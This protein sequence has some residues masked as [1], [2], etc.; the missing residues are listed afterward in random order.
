MKRVK[1]IVLCIGFIILYI[2]L[3]ILSGGI[4]GFI[5]LWLGT[6]RAMIN[7]VLIKQA[8]IVQILAVAL[9]IIAVNGY[10]RNENNKLWDEKKRTS[11]PKLWIASIML[12]LSYSII[13]SILTRNYQFENTELIKSSIEYYSGISPILGYGFMVISVFVMA[14][15]GE[16]L[17]FRRVL[18]NVLRKNYSTY[19]TIIISSLF[20]GAIHLMAGGV[21]LAMGALIMGL[22]LGYIYICTGG[23]F[24]IVVI[25]HALANCADFIL[26]VL[27]DSVYIAFMIGLLIICGICIKYIHRKAIIHH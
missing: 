11:S 13:W 19:S 12:A 3:Q 22:I 27:P 8:F 6:E 21:T 26:M 2:G 9:F 24:I 23:S 25:S 10:Q 16:E 17:L 5:H 1:S 14:P 20:F 7:D 18:I 4:I 15:I